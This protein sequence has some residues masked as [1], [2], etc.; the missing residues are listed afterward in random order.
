[1]LTFGRRPWVIAARVIVA[2]VYRLIAALAPGVFSVSFDDHNG[3]VP[4][5]FEAVAVIVTLVLLGPGLDG[6]V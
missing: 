3:Q 4:L 1:M 5:Y 2:D 6:S